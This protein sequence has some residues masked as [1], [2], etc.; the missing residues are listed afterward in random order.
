MLSKRWNNTELRVAQMGDEDL[1]PVLQWKE[2][3]GA[4]RP[5]WQ[6]VASHS[7]KTKAYWAQWESLSIDNGVL[8]CLW[9]TPAGDRSI[10]QIV[11]P[12]A[13]RTEVLQQ[14]HSSPTAG[15]LGEVRDR[16]CWVQ[17]SKDVHTFCKNCDLCSSLRGPTTKRRVPLDQYNA[18]APMERLA[19]DVLG[20]LP[21]TEAGNKYLLITAD[22][23]TKWVEAYPLPNQEAVTVAE[24]LVKNFVCQF[25]VPLI[26]HSFQERN[27]ES[28]V[29]PEMCRLLGIHKTR[30]TPLH[31]QSDGMVERF[32]R[33]IKDQ[34]QTFHHKQMLVQ[35]I[36]KL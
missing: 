2:M 28:L 30:T 24:A 17:C 27:F 22:Y 6:S 10:K 3:D 35:Q 34:H 4:T 8:Y 21:T 13:L 25:G 20:P 14:F 36:T 26:I 33:T 12:N 32:N 29:F 1:S 19:I 16:F 5:P 11:L 23:F 15:H 9:E 18:V 7:E 31:P